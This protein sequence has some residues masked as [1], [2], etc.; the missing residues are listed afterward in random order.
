MQLV[1]SAA[2]LSAD[3]LQWRGGKAAGLE[4]R[5]SP[6]VQTETP[7][8]TPANHNRLWVPSLLRMPIVRL[9]VELRRPM[10]AAG[11]TILCCICYLVDL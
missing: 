9:A 6:A 10:L 4:K 8:A 3:V 7:T 2:D 11:T 1:E 5:S